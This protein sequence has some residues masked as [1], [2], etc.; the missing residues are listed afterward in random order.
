LAA[1]SASASGTRS[2]APDDLAGLRLAYVTA[3]EQ[4]AAATDLVYRAAG[5]SAIFERGGIERCWRDVHAVTQHF[6][7]SPRH[8]ERIGRITLGLDPGPGPI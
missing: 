7:V 3:A 1:T 5:S 2:L 6:A 8:L 4:A